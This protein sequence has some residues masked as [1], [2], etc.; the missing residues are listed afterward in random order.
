M[1]PKKPTIFFGGHGTDS[2][3]Y[4]AFH[5]NPPLNATPA[6]NANQTPSLA[7]LTEARTSTPKFSTTADAGSVINSTPAF[8]TV[9]PAGRRTQATRNVQGGRGVG[10]AGR[11]IRPQFVIQHLHCFMDPCRHFRSR[12]IP[13]DTIKDITKPDVKKLARDVR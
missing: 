6:F 11:R 4:Y 1:A 12:E 10:R 9:A 13:K 8:V 5:T 3:A 2:T 7:D